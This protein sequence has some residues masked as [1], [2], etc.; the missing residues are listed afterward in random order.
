VVKDARNYAS[1]HQNGRI[2]HLTRDPALL[3]RD[4]RP[5]SVNADLPAMYAE[6]LPLYARFR[7][8]AMKNDGTAAETAAAVWRDF[9][10]HSGD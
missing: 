8:A 9:C 2:Y 6:R 10:E 7:D 3:E 1:L 4:G 5:L